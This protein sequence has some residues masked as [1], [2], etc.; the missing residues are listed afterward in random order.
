MT[1]NGIGTDDLDVAFPQDVTDVA[2]G[3]VVHARIIRHGR[4][5]VR[6]SASRCGSRNRDADF[7]LGREAK[8]QAVLLGVISLRDLL[9][10]LSEK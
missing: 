7:A 9:Q 3:P 8:N 6:L 5:C 2:S 1:R 4:M 10:H